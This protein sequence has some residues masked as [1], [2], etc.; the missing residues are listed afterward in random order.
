MYLGILLTFS[1][2]DGLSKLGGY[3]LELILTFCVDGLRFIS[4]LPLSTYSG[5]QWDTFQLILLYTVFIFLL[6]ASNYRDKRLFYV[7]LVILLPLNVYTVIKNFAY[8]TYVGC[9]IY[10]VRSAI[11]IATIEQGHVFLF[12][13]LD[14]L[15]HPTIQF[16]VLPDLLRFADEDKIVFVHLKNEQRSNYSIK[17][18]RCSFLILERELYNDMF[19]AY[20]FILWR[21]DNLNNLLDFRRKYEKSI[22]IIDGSN[23]QRNINILMATEAN[24]PFLYL[25]KNN[26]AYVWVQE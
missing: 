23:S 22:I 1:P 6:I 17:V 21:K 5:I 3:L 20:D 11:A 10:N 19:F 24:M 18:G 8:A 14:S 13:T 16:S 15:R 26:F 7:S 4:Q 25:L 9:R 12:S 2:L